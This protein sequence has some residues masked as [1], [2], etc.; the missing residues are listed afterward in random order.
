MINGAGKYTINMSL[1][2]HQQQFTKDISL[3][4]QKADNL[5]VK[6]TFG[7]AYRTVDQQLLYYYGMSI[8]P[9]DKRLSLLSTK[10]RS[11]TLYSNHL[12]RLAVDFNFFIVGILTYTDPKIEELG[13]YWESLNKH[14]RWGG[15]FKGYYD[16]PHF[17]RNI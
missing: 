11:R 10:S 1:V 4:I 2:L 13:M 9:E 7:E 5:G 12:R 8:R 17:E 6:L 15:N 14:N 16:A 3:L